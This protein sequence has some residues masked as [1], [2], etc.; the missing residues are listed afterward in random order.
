M[1]QLRVTKLCFF[2]GKG[3][4]IRTGGRLSSPVAC[5]SIGLLIASLAATENREKE[6]DDVPS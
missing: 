6:H 3:G 4:L 1:P 2:T 5:L